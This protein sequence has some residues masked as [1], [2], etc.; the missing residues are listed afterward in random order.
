[1]QATR[2]RKTISAEPDYVRIHRAAVRLAHD[3]N[4]NGMFRPDGYPIAADDPQNITHTVDD[5]VAICEA[6][7]RELMREGML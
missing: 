2:I 4:S 3:I 5:L 1:M 7:I 6:T